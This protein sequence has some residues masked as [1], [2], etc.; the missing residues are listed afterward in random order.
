MQAI[1]TGRDGI[2]RAGRASA[3]VLAILAIGLAAL[4]A[5]ACTSDDDPPDVTVEAPAA[6]TSAAG[7]SSGASSSSSSDDADDAASTSDDD[8]DDSGGASS[9]D[10][11]SASDDD[12]DDDASGT[13]S[14]QN[15]N[16]DGDGPDLDT[17]MNDALA[18]AASLD[19]ATWV[20]EPAITSPGELVFEGRLA[21][22][23][24]LF[25]PQG[26]EGYAF[27]VFYGDH[28]EP[29]V[30]LLPDLGPFEQWRTDLTIAPTEHE[31]EAQSFRV[32]AYS[33]LFMDVGNPTE[34][35]LRVYGFDASGQPG[36]LAVHEIAGP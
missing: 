17:S 16:P 26:G 14:N 32:R 20:V 6:A 33:P 24:L 9:G 25:D 10:A 21:A 19:L 36:L 22:G 13:V 2:R 15:Q 7:G 28:D 31:I 30:V 1:D 23:A 8:S 3:A 29:M 11:V 35:H 27:A 5:A 12:N 34:L 4:A 18:G